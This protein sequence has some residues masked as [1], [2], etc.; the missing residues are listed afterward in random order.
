MPRFLV[1]LGRGRLENDG[2]PSPVRFSGLRLSDRDF[3]PGRRG[4]E[5]GWR[6][7]VTCAG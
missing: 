3:N 5:A 7:P 6:C 2:E 1:A 4:G